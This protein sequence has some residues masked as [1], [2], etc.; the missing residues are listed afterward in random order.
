MGVCCV[1]HSNNKIESNIIKEKDNKSQLNDDSN[2]NDNDIN[3]NH[4][5]TNNKDKNISNT[6]GPIFQLLLKKSM[7]KQE[8]NNYFKEL[9]KIKN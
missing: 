2:I 3:S 7:T 8:N 5:I 6:T 1:Y 9:N 4:K